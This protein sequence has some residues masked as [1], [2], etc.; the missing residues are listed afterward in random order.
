[1]FRKRSPLAHIAAFRKMLRVCYTHDLSL[2]NEASTTRAILANRAEMKRRTKWRYRLE[3][4]D[5]ERFSV[6]FSNLCYSF[7][8]NFLSPSQS[9]SAKLDE[10]D[11]EEE[12][13][14]AFRETMEKIKEMDESYP[15]PILPSSEWKRAAMEAIAKHHQEDYESGDFKVR[16][17]VL[18]KTMF[19]QWH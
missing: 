18:C 13:L 19:T 16:N 1:M 7:A 3:S 6:S 4:R 5:P 10:Q 2:G 12:S 17:F 11:R 8:S 14:Y 9:Y 15:F